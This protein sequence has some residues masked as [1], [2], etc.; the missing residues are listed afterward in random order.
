MNSVSSNDGTEVCFEDYDLLILGSGAA[1]KLTSWSLARQ[2]MKTAVVERKYIGG[3]CPNIACLPSKNLIHSAKIALH[4]AIFT[5]PTMSE[6][7]IPVFAGVPSAPAPKSPV[8]TKTL[9]NA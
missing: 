3:A 7:L 8:Q 9:A 5:H 2:G 4:D 6:G 1:G